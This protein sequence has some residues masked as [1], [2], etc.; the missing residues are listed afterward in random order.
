MVGES[1]KINNSYVDLYFFKFK[2]SILYTYVYLFS[3]ILISV[4][5]RKIFN[6]YNFKFNFTLMF[7]QQFTTMIVFIKVF[8]KFDNYK[9]V[10]GEVSFNEFKEKIFPISLFNVIFVLN[11]LSS[12]IGN[13]MV[14]TQMFLCLRKYL[15][16]MTYLYDSYICKKN[17]PNYFTTS[18][19]LITVGT[20]I[21]S[22]S[23]F[24]LSKTISHLIP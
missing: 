13:Q 11:I 21:S 9:K 3:S 22:V 4:I 17:L 15:L 18:V 6:S 16:I 14:N 10:V 5:N 8:S 23:I 24:Y 2:K 7:I 19:I 12:F 1:E 20:T